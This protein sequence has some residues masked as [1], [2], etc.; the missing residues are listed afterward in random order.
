MVAWIAKSSAARS[1]SSARLSPM[2][3]LHLSPEPIQHQ[4]R[5][6][7][8]AA[9]ARSLD[10]SGEESMSRDVEVRCRC[11]T[12]EGRVKN[13]SPRTVNRVVCYCADCQAFAHH[14]KRADL[15]DSQG[16]SDIVQVAPAALEFHRGSDR[17]AGLHLTPNA[18]FRWYAGCCNTPIGNLVSPAIPFV[19]IVAQAFQN[20]DADFGKPI[21]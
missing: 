1:R 20:P 5:R 14:L 6:R 16:G 21:G 4:S 15:L 3:S 8:V 18:L 10:D 12:V 13:A 19:G 9:A 7:T 2:T 11:G 17:I